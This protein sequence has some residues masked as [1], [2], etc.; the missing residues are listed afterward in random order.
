[1]RRIPF[2]SAHFNPVPIAAA[3]SVSAALLGSLVLQGCISSSPV[4]SKI[5]PPRFSRGSTQAPKL[6]SA[7]P[8]IATSP[9]PTELF[10]VVKVVDGDTLHVRRKG[11]IQKLRLL[12]V[13]T[14]ERLG[15][16]FQ[17]SPTK[18]QTVFGEECALWAQKF[19]A[20]LAKDGQP[21]KVGLLFPGGKEEQDVYG[22]LLCHVLLPDGTD[23][24]LMLVQKGKSPYFNKYGNSTVSHEAFVAAQKAAQVAKLGIWDPKTNEPKTPGTPAAKRPYPELLAWWEARAQAID[25]FRKHAAESPAEWIDSADPEALERA[26]ASP[27]EV[28][29]FGEIDRLY[30]EETGDQTV[31]M[32]ATHKEAALRI[33]IP[34]AVREKHAG[35]EL[36]AAHKEFR[37]NYFF[38]HGRIEH[39]A[40]G[41]H[42]VS[43]AATRWRRAGPE[44]VLPT[45]AK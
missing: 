24:N 41:Y 33:R 26:S 12:S 9:A 43:E 23:Y 14:E 21:P 27:K 30:D 19:F 18:P 6:A 7:P 44:P 31:L 28:D 32:R 17:G 13:D 25:T 15:N 3:L 40:R 42:M 35:L 34:Q 29:A 39:T 22:R 8:A 16:G 20:D 45:P 4:D 5:A 36:A 11:E 37:Q 38:I 10:E 2:C 1:M